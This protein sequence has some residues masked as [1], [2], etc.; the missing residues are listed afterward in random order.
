MEG[1]QAALGSIPWPC[2]ITAAKRS[3]EESLRE[4]MTAGQERKSAKADGEQV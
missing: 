2:A 4:A 3:I 1:V